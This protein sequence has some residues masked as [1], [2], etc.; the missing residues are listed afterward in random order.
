MRGVNIGYVK[1]IKLRINSVVILI[2]IQSQEFLIPKQC[3]IETNQVGLFN[4][5]VID[6]IP[7]IYTGVTNKSYIDVFTNSCFN[8]NFLCHNDYIEGYRGLNY[9]DLIRAATRISQRFD[10]PRFFQ[11]FYLCLRNFIDISDEIGVFAN[12]MSYI[13]SI[14]IDLIDIYLV[15]YIF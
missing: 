3:I 4:N 9:D 1:I 5:T 12:Y 10:D 13:V 8:S 2:N 11:V 15:K 7:I 6:I 14:L